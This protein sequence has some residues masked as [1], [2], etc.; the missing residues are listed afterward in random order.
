MWSLVQ[1]GVLFFYGFDPF[2]LSII[3]MIDFDQHFEFRALNG[4]SVN[5]NVSG[6]SSLR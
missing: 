6:T 5:S 1:S 3:S 2:E 4:D